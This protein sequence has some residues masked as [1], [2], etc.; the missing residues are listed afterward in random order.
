MRKPIIPSQTI[1][2]NYPVVLAVQATVTDL[3]CC[4][5][6]SIVLGA[7]ATIADPMCGS[8][9]FLIEAVLMAR[10]VAP[11]LN[12]TYW[13]FQQWV[14]F[15]RRAWGEAVVSSSVVASA[16]LG[17]WTAVILGERWSR[18]EPGCMPHHS[19]HDWT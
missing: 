17:R 16:A 8:G 19:H 10:N 6:L 9:T 18:D 12:R 2:G 4:T 7:G 3:M 13:P 5:H 15:D 11:G 14:D 1:L